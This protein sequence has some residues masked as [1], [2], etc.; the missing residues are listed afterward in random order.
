MKFN[1]L[2]LNSFILLV[3]LFSVT[4]ISAADLNDTGSMDVLKDVN[5]NESSFTDFKTEL[6]V[7]DS[8]LDLSG[9]Y[10]FDNSSGLDSNTGIYINKN[11]FVINGNNH[12]ID[13]DNQAR[14]FNITGK[15]VT[16]NNLIIKNGVH[17][18]GSAIATN[19]ALTLN[20]VTFINC[21]GTGTPYNMGAI[22]SKEAPLIVN[23]CKFIDTSG[24]EGASITSYGGDVTVNNSTFI[25][26]SDKI[27]KGQIYVYQA[28]LK[29]LNSIFLNTTSKYATAIFCE[30][31]CGIEINNTKFRN[32]FANK[33]AGAISVKENINM[34]IN[35]CEFV[36]VSSVNNGGAIFLDI[37]GNNQTADGEVEINNC[38]F[39][40]CYSSFGGALLQLGGTIII[41]NSEFTSNKANYEG[42]AIYTSFATVGI[43]DSKFRS[44]SLQDEISYGGACYFDMGTVN[45][46]RNI[47]ENNLA[48]NVTTIYAYD[49]DLTLRNNYFENPSNVTSIYTVY[50]TVTDKKNNNFTNDKR[51][52]GNTND[53]YN[54]E[55]SAKPFIILNNTISYDEMPAKFDLRDYGWVTPV[56]DQGFMGACWMFGNL[57]ALESALLRYTNVTYSLSENN[58][59]NSMIQYSK[60]GAIGFIEGGAEYGAIAYLT[61]WLGVFPSKY[62]SYDEL[63]KISSL[64]ITPEDIHIQNAAVLPERKNAG[65]NSL[66]KDAIIR[67]GAVATSH[68]AD[69]DEKKYFNKANSAQYY[70]GKKTAD[71]RVCI[72]GWDD[73]YSANNFLKT[74]PGNGA[75]IVKN[76]WGTD[77]GDEGYFY[78]SYYD[79]SLGSDDNI[80]YIINNDTFNR[81]YQINAGGEITEFNAKYYYN[82][83]TADEDELIAAVGTYFKNAGQKYAF[84]IIVNG[85]VVYEQ[86]GVSDLK[87]FETIK[88]NKLVQIKK[89]DTFKI[90]FKAKLYSVDNLRIHVKKGQSFASNDGK[91]WTDLAKKDS[92]AIIKAY[93]VSDLNI[94]ESL[95][96]YYTNKDPFVAKV[97]PGETVV[98]EYNG[99]T[100]TRQADENGLAKL[101]IN[102]KPGKYSITTTYNNTSIV[103]YIIIKNTVVS[104]NINKTI[105]SNFKYKLRVLDSNGKAVKNTKVL[106]TVNGKSKYYKSDK[107][108]YIT[109]KFT[110]LAKNQKITVKNPKT[111]E[112]KTSKIGAYSRFTE[113][114]NVVMY[115]NDGS[116]FKAQILDDNTKPVGKNK[117]VILMINKKIYKVKTNS[118]GYI[119]FKIPNTL[120]PGKYILYGLYKSNVNKNII[121][122]KQNLKTSKYTVKKSAKKL[123]VKATLKNGKKAVKNK[124]ITLK[125]NGKKYSAKT[126]AKGIAKFTVKKNVISKL[127]AGKKYTMTVTYIKNTIKT[128][129]K[130]KS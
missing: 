47:F 129:L 105:N 5:T 72:V 84:S 64:Y 45:L 32:L 117:V 87:G 22:Y 20:N 71:H 13:C 97:G 86:T 89:G 111:G 7:A 4:A 106:I 101:N 14:A 68:H 96:K 114:K 10:K 127:K 120:K 107:S 118:K 79:L 63:G 50:G 11:T 23:D 8:S 76:S 56:K 95:V 98:F 16:I 113:D 2:I 21:I 1:K 15:K 115:Y 110:K 109:L 62:D 88:L 39:Y 77:W 81:I 38:K 59:Q 49:T 92:V 67:Y 54:F 18:Y 6:F 94:T 122:V 70:Y 26:N 30:H 125:L 130:V 29:V 80:Y 48:S 19:T 99:K 78:V 34:D 66:I 91:T 126:N 43:A 51:S 31:K 17:D 58:A 44:N 85:V 27:I 75:W 104:S 61:D 100:Y 116:K 69:F 83:F 93:T 112:I 37:T 28:D 24:E 128:T 55:N 108:G 73:N 35:D 33:T 82:S 53:F 90:K 57:A 102:S 36:N 3:L 40:D 119:T 41:K 52:F 123:T 42:G 9:N 103:N 60:Y 46:A 74:P 25:S 12:I 65:D 121:K 124:K